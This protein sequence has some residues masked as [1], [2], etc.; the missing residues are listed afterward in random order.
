[1]TIGAIIITMIIAAAFGVAAIRRLGMSDAEQ[2]LRLL[3]EAG[4]KNLDDMFENLEENVQIVSSYVESD[5]DGLSDEEFQMHL[6]RVS[7]V[8][9][10]ILVNTNGI[11]TYYYRIDPAV[12]SSVEGFWFVNLDGEDFV[13][14]K[15]T[16]ITQYDTNDTSQLVWFTVPKA[17]GEPVWL[18]PYITDNLDVRVISYNVPVYFNGQFVGV[19][20]IELDYSAMAA[21]VDNI[22]LYEN[23]YAFIT[24]ADGTIVYHPHMSIPELEAREKAPDGIVS[25]D[26]IVRYRYKGVEKLAYRLPLINGNLLTVSAPLSEIN[27]SWHKW[28]AAIIIAFLALLFVFIAFIRKYSEQITKPLQKL[29]EAAEQIDEGNYD[30]TLDYDGKDEIGALTNTFRRVTENL[31]EY[32]SRLNDLAYADALTSV[33]N[34]GAFEIMIRDM[35]TRLDQPEG[36]PVFAVCMFDCNFLKQINDKYGHDKGDIYLKETARII[37]DVF[38]HSPVF[39]IGGDEFVVMLQERDYENREALLRLFDEKCAEKRESETDP[40]KKVDVSRG[41][42]DY[43]PQKDQSIADV[44]RRAD[45]AMYEDKRSTGNTRDGSTILLP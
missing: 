40:W 20:G 35:Q 28:I 26:S 6:D 13:P 41:M 25:E 34:R 37:C 15:V 18:R 30:C 4:E 22:T 44:V 32:I 10:R 7:E 42:A 12:S 23:G 36:S 21:Q 19:I 39:R 3:C 17:T 8:F 24:E 33:H 5:L 9:K 43:D 31:K 45:R 14:H 38:A 1:M 27:A 29:T 2:M 11:V 16:D